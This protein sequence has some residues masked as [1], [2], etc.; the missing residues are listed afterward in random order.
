MDK[1]YYVYIVT[2]STN[3]VT[4]TGVTN[5]LKR[6][7]YE[8]KSNLGKGFTTMYN[9]NR[10]VYYEVFG[11]AENAIT[12]EKQIK[13]GSRKAKVALI[14]SINKDWHDLYAEL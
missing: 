8:H 2:N 1:Q 13:A 12:R 10:L 11:D 6:R 5:D 3:T 4:Y 7:I 9:I 14:N